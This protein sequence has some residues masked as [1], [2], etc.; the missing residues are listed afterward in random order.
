MRVIPRDNLMQ[1]R[2]VQHC[3]PGGATLVK[4]RSTSDEAIT[5]HCAISRLYPDRVGEGRRLAD[6]SARVCTDRQGCHS[7]RQRR[8][9]AT[10]G[11]TRCPGKIPRIVCRPIGGVFR[12]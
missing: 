10:A 5:R 8:G 1:K 3:A 9:R 2:G 12:G 11:A 7:R 6:R 4:R